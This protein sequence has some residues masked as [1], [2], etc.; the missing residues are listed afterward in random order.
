MVQHLKKINIFHLMICLLMTLANLSY[1]STSGDN[2]K[3]LNDSINLNNYTLVNINNI[4]MWICSDG[5]FSSNPYNKERAGTKYPRG[6]IPI[7]WLNGLCW[8]GIVTDNENKQ[9][10][11]GGTIYADWTKTLHSTQPGAILSPGISEKF[12]N[13][14]VSIWRICK[15]WQNM[16][17]T[18]DAA[19]YFNTCPDSVTPEQ[20]NV[21]RS[22]YENDW[23]NWPWQKG[24]PFIDNNNNGIMDTNEQPGIAGADQ[25][26]WFVCNDLDSTRAYP[27]EVSPIGLEIQYTIWAYNQNN[28]DVNDNLQNTIFTR[29]RF[30]YKGIK[31]TINNAFI[32]S[33]FIGI[34]ADPDIG[35]YK[36]DFVGCDTVLDLGFGYNSCDQDSV[37]LPQGIIPPVIGFSLLQGPKIKSVNPAIKNDDYFSSFIYN[38]M[39]SFFYSILNG[40]YD[41]PRKIWNAKLIY[42]ALQFLKPDFGVPF[43]DGNG[44]PIKFPVSGDPITGIGNI[45][46]YLEDK[47]FMVNTGPFKIALG[48]TQ[49]V[50]YAI[51]GGLGSNHLNSIEVVKQ[52][53][54]WTKDFYNKF[55]T[56]SSRICYGD[57]DKPKSYILNQNY[58]NPFNNST[59][60]SFFI[61][62]KTLVLLEIFN[63]LGKKVD[64]IVNEI[65]IPGKYT[66]Y[67]KPNNISSGLYFCML[68]TKTNIITKKIIVQK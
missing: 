8:G 33:M 25:V 14:D 66:V 35:D 46:S 30:I 12:L 53:T 50:F 28:I 15:N 59:S 47:C 34:F 2:K 41:C 7:I 6:T 22:N 3:A 18:N 38:R 5:K 65:L 36:N 16:E 19:E 31:T 55:V 58:P 45:D 57:I 49:D 17:L 21:L 54:Q 11:S 44:N 1:S 61:P 56:S 64:T 9:L 4:S 13:S 10:K 43:L 27:N 48:D 51:I 37:F 20:I 62:Q 52:R 63:L 24:A 67:W 68:K 29:A 42:Y 26:V 60:I 39:S 40:P 23:N 32:D